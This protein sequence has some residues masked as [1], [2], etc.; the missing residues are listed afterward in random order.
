MNAQFG[1]EIVHIVDSHCLPGKLVNQLSFQQG[2]VEKR[3]LSVLCPPHVS[4]FGL[5]PVL[6]SCHYELICV[7]LCLSCYLWFTCVFIVL[8]VHFDFVWSTRY[9]WCFLS[10]LSCLVC[11]KDYYLSLRPPLRV[12]LPPCCVHRD[13]IDTL[14][15]FFSA[16]TCLKGLVHIN[17]NILS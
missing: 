10:A 11:I 3:Y 9:S 1:L 6:V 4:I 17:I 16:G 8:S 7:Q 14:R 15:I 5:F 12:L 13:S 2:W